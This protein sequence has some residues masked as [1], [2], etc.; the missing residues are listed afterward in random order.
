MLD[1]EQIR[2]KTE[3]IKKAIARKG[4]DPALIDEVILI[5]RNRR[6]VLSE[7]ER[8][9]SELNKYSKD[10]AKFHGQQKID[11]IN[12]ASSWSAKVKDLKPETDQ[13]QKEFTEIMLAIPNPPADDVMDGASDKDNK[14]NRTVGELP[15]FSFKPQDHVELGEKLDLIDIERAGKISGSRFYFLKNELV[16]LEFALIQYALEILT[17]E[18]FTPMIPPILLNR[19]TMTGAGYLPAGEDEIYKTQDDLFLAGTSE[20][21]LAGYHSGEIVD[22][23]NLPLRYTGFSSCFRREAGSHGK[24]VRGILRAHQFDK[25]EMFSFC[26]P[27]DSEKEHEYLVSLEEKIVSGLGLPYQ[28]IDICAGDLGAP[29]VKK[30]DIETWMPGQNQYRET[31]S[32]SNCSDFQARRLNIRFRDKDGKVSPL[33]T[34]NGTAIAIGRMLIAIMENGQQ[35]DG[36]IKIPEVLHK[37]LNFKEIKR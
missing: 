33:H 7:L 27:K 16:Q 36:S 21:P 29:A 6:R 24:D 37:F 26:T 20:Q 11:A 13:A 2:T 30:Y 34:L 28:I 4:A 8:A 19:E 5:D 31:H 14:V 22:E 25:I 15:K 17:A 9:Q 32:C 23:K 10:I 12:E 35:K 3:E 18:K 1:I